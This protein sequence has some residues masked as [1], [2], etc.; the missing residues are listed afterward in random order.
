ML[1]QES[2]SG[3]MRMRDTDTECS[4]MIKMPDKRLH[5]VTLVS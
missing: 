5:C 1:L 3:E 2:S 4:R